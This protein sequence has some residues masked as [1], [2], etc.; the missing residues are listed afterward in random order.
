M[1]TN[2]VR[3]CCLFT[4]RYAI[5][6]SSSTLVDN[7]APLQECI[8]EVYRSPPKINSSIQVKGWV[9]GVRSSKNVAF[10]DLV[11]GTTQK[12]IKCVIR[13]PSLLPEGVKPGV[14][15]SV[16]G[17]WSEGKGKQQYE[18]QL[19]KY[20][21]KDA[22]IDVIGGVEDLYPLL[23]KKHT[24]Q[25]LRTIPEYRWR[26]PNAAAILRF[27]SNVEKSM[28]DF[29][30][31]YSF[32]KTHPPVTTSSDCEGAGEMFKIDAASDNPKDANFFGKE[33][34]LTVS[35]QL[36]LEVLCE[37]L[38]R[39]WTITPC[40]RAERSDTNRHLSEFWMLEAEMAFVNNVRQLTDFSE[41]MIKYVVRKLMLDEDD[42]R[43]NLLATAT[44]EEA[45]AM[46][47]RW[48]MLIQQ[49]K[50]ATI[51]YTQ[52]IHV[53][54]EAHENGKADFKYKPTWGESLKSE[55][56]KWLA[57]KYFKNPVFVTDYPL[58]QKAFYMKVN[59]PVGYLEKLPPTVACY[60]MLVPDIGEL[61][62]GS[63]RE[64]NYEKLN[65]EIRRRK[66]N[67]QSLEWY[68][69]QRKNGTIPHGGFG[70]GFERLLQYL[71]CKDNI[72]DVI[73]FPRTVNN[74][75]C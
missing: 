47:K 31:Y 32:T 70:M 33:A 43:S 67:T 46:K 39:V 61:I 66:M 68:L 53:L 26:Q 60:D 71:T 1:F 51:T 7:A 58:D 24:E 22:K 38:S 34:Y 18:L 69:A 62:G 19:N 14:S 56:E 15:L 54:R 50:W 11:D 29:F 64:E 30:D 12:D 41:L 17:I 6:R 52:A 73:A 9:S 37:A 23:K 49:D 21:F 13:P 48:Q 5:L 25:F 72:K 20:K 63:V 75:L 74:C 59:E 36:H 10:V 28:V 57:G 27:R 8:R 35:T 2:Q 42:M 45:E 4:Q 40:F 44:K 3:R 65:S 16:D 55:H